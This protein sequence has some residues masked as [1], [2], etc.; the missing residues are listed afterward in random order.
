MPDGPHSDV[1]VGLPTDTSDMSSLAG[2]GCNPSLSRSSTTIQFYQKT[3]NLYCHRL[4]IH[5][6]LTFTL[7]PFF[8]LK[9]SL[10]LHV[11]LIGWI[12]FR[13]VPVVV[14]FSLTDER[15][16]C[17]QLPTTGNSQGLQ[18]L[19]PSVSWKA[20]GFAFASMTTMNT[21]TQ[22]RRTSFSL[23]LGQCSTAISSRPQAPAGHAKQQP[24]QVQGRRQA[25]LSCHRP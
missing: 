7:S 11:L 14:V 2:L 4:S 17:H 8:L 24:S 3:I 16:A 12:L 25:N 22:S 21:F 9:E 13:F 6:V 15:S 10:S 5:N 1:S 19:P 23:A 18:R 20:E